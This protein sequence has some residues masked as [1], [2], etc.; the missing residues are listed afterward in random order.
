MTGQLFLLGTSQPAWLERAGVPLFLSDTRLRGRKTLPRAAAPCAFDSGGFSELQKHGIWTIPPAEYVARL[1]RYRDEIG[2]TL[3][4]APQDWMCE[5][6]I[7][8]G[9]VFGGQRFVGTHLSVVEHQRR[10][11]DNYLH[12]RDLASDLPIKPAVQGDTPDDYLR[13]VEMYDQ[14]GIELTAEPLVLVGSVCRRQ[15]TRDAGR[16]LTALRRAGLTRLHGLGFKTLGLLQFGHLLTSADSLAWSDVARKLRRPTPDCPGKIRTPG[17]PVK[18]CANCLHYALTWRTRLLG[19]LT[20]PT[21]QLQLW[22]DEP[23]A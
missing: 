19:Q 18:N 14:A 20:Q 21:T 22:E 6:A 3:W 5:P 17:T 1:Y 4:F 15:G 8:N 12:L 10:T 7:I 16:I 2:Q 23:A 11:V 9:G 13:C